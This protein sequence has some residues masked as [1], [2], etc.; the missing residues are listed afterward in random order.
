MFR[1]TSPS[2]RASE[3][4]QR[5]SSL[6]P[7]MLA[8]ALLFAAPSRHAEA[9]DPP[10]AMTLSASISN[11]DVT[12][13]WS[14]PPSGTASFDIVIYEL[15]PVGNHVV[16]RKLS[17]AT[18][19]SSGATTHLFEDPAFAENAVAWYVEIFARDANGHL[20]GTAASAQ[21]NL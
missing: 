7:T 13:T 15:V 3:R 12:A 18:G 2:S 5:A 1:I 11:G 21:Q 19:L 20:L 17:S 14:N 4:T 10:P 9:Q 16:P 8:A 6:I